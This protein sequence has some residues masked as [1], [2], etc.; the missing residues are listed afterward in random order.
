MRLLN[1]KTLQLELF[2]GDV[3]DGIPEYAILSHVWGAEEV[4]FSEYITIKGCRE[5]AMRR[6]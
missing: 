2:F 5:K 1:V 3:G 4:T 6:F